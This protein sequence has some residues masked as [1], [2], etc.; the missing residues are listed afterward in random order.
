[1]ERVIIIVLDSL[2]VGELPDAAQYGDTGSNTLGHVAEAVGGLKLPNLGGLGL[3]NIIPILGVPRVANPTGCYGKMAERSVG[4]DST[5]G[6]WELSGIVTTAPFPLYPHGFPPEVID[7]FEKAIGRGVLGNY[8]ASGTVIIDQLGE[9]HLRTGKPIVYTSADSVFQIAA[10]EEVVPLDELYRW[11]GVARD[12]L[13]GPHAVARVIARPFLGKP[14]SFYRTPGRRDFSLPPPEK[15]VLDRVFESGGEVIAIGKIQD[16]FAD[17]GITEAFHGADNAE[18]T[19]LTLHAIELLRGKLVFSNL[20]DFD[21][22]Y[23]HRNDPQ[24]YAA[25]LEAFDN[26]L[27]SLL[28]AM[29]EN[30]LLIITADHGCD[31]TTESTDHSR[32]Y[33]PVL[34][35]GHSLKRGID[36]GTRAGFCDVAGTV[37]EALGIESPSCA[38][39]FLGDIL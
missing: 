22:K 8:A 5:T 34:A 2:G 14:G 10:H 11:C 29:G 24:G 7:A 21:M 23:G 31:P 15:T 36:L 19:Q 6:H 27:P 25:A 4:K 1:M 17:R 18:V 39:S 26:E 13:Q 20:V 38:K 37:C 12:T 30:D 28:A 16:L 32:E 33:V 3:G 35:F 9:E